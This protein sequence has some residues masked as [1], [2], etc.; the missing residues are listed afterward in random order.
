MIFEGDKLSMPPPA[1][2]RLPVLF[3]YKAREAVLELQRSVSVEQLRT[4]LRKA[5]GKTGR[6]SG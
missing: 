1:S 4:D 5:I 6:R 3:E 2:G